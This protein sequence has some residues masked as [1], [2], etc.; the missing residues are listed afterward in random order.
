MS[1]RTRSLVLAFALTGLALAGACAEPTRDDEV[2]DDIVWAQGAESYFAAM[3]ESFCC[4][5][6]FQPAAF[7]LPSGAL[8]LRMFGGLIAKTAEEVAT[9]LEYYS[10]GPDGTRGEVV[11]DEGAELYDRYLTAW[12]RPDPE[13][14]AAVYT[15]FAMVEDTLSGRTWSGRD[16]I[17]AGIDAEAHATFEAGPWPSLMS[18]YLD[19]RSE[20][21]A[22]VQT[23][24]AC[25]TREAR[26]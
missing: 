13:T 17:L 16:D 19:G 3:T 14:I 10:T 1:I 20:L 9:S 15:P 12:S 21:L 25:P 6:D 2:S 8:D 11:L 5:A 24:G 23:T 22:V 4:E 26:R 7:F 18:F